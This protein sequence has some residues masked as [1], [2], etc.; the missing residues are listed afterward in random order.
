MERFGSGWEG[1]SGAGDVTPDR[2]VSSDGRP[3]EVGVPE[4]RR[5]RGFAGSRGEAIVDMVPRGERVDRR[6]VEGC[7]MT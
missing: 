2:A 1:A 6:W 4:G 3:D 7:D 5:R